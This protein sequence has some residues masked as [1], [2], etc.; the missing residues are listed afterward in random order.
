MCKSLA[1]ELRLRGYSKL[2]KAELIQMIE[3]HRRNSSSNILDEP[4]PEINVPI[5]KPMQFT[6]K[7]KVA[8][9]KRLAGKISKRVIKKINKFS[10]WL[11][12]YIPEPVKNTASEKLNKLKNDVKRIFNQ[13]ERFKIE[14]IESSLKGYLKTYRIK[15]VK[16]Y[17]CIS[18]RNIVHIVL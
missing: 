14:E 10:D 1:K 3:D 5:L 8:P 11:I 16:G 4:V 7:N 15:G 12:S 17:C 13:I 9:L 6:A 18:Q 2:R